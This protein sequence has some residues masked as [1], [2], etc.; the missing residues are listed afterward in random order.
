MQQ[1]DVVI[2]GAGFGG[3]L[4]ALLLDRIGLSVAVI[5][6]GTHP[7]F[8]IGES[9]T[10][11]AGYLLQSLS[12]KYDLPQFQPFCK[13][14]SWQQTYPDIACGVKRGFSY[15][16]HQPGQ[17]FQIDTAHSSELLVTAN[18]S[19]TLADTHW[20]RADVDEFFA[21]EVKKSNVVSLDQTQV[22]L[23]RSDGWEI[24]GSRDGE[25][26]FLRATFLIDASGA[27]GLVP[28]ALGI[29]PQT[30]FA[31]RSRAIYGHFRDVKL[32]D[33][34]LEQS[35]VD[36]S[37][38]PFACDL[39]ALH[40]V[41]QEGWMWQ[42]RFNNG[43]TSAGFVLDERQTALD[44]RQ[45][46]ARYPAIQAQFAEA[47][48]VAPEAGLVTTGRL[49]RGWTECAGP[50]WALLPHTA[51]FIDPLHSTGIAQ[52]L[53][54]IERL[55]SVLEQHWKKDSRR[56]QLADYSESLQRERAL[57]DRLVACCYR[58]RFDFNLFTASTLFYF[59]AATSFEYQR[60][61]EQRQPLLLCADDSEF[62]QTVGQW[63]ELVSQLE[64][65]F[66]V[67]Q[68][69]ISQAVKQAEQMLAPWNRVGLF[70]PE[71]PNMYYYT[72]APEL[73]PR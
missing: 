67:P 31:T 3:S 37:D 71:V 33:E 28:R 4:T 9:S 30:E 29:R 22:E 26:V 64:Q 43:I 6:R 72:A 60:S 34:V 59:A 18:L 24:S 36:R 11:A 48:V 7:R 61:Q 49:Q 39:A 51:G 56:E 58:S 44:W 38:Y 21:Q 65:Q 46:L 63:L 19:E 55:V 14:G 54:G 12:Q 53:C 68:D 17:P 13:Y 10:P 69:E 27:A 41:L 20:Y 50:D 70:Q 52:T 42:L 8:S 66:P 5:D 62:T 73:E 23:Q 45:M 32:W 15:F 16:A 35:Q 47:A 40:H 2:L 57:I 1:F 25:E